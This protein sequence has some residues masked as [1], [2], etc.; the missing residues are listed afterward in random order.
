MKID[1]LASLGILGD[2][3]QRLG[4]ENPD[5]VSRDKVI[6]KMSPEDAVSTWCGWTLG[7]EGWGQKIIGLYKSLSEAKKELENSITCQTEDELRVLVELLS[8]PPFKYNASIFDRRISRLRHEAVTK[9]NS[10]KQGQFQRLRHA[11]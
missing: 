8:H 11:P 1:T 6:E 9:W 5:D 3:R 10:R 7:D 2:I 4:A